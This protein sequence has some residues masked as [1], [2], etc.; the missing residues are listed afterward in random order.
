MGERIIVI[1]AGVVLTV[2]GYIEIFDFVDD[3]KQARKVENKSIRYIVVLI[4]VALASYLNLAYMLLFIVGI[5]AI[6][7]GIFLL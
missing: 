1:F 2:I 5:I 4:E 3:I 7:S 6:I